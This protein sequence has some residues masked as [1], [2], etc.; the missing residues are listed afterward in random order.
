[1]PFMVWTDNNLLNYV[2]TTLNLDATG[3]TCVGALASFEFTLEYQKGTDNGA[4]DALSQVPICLG[5]ETVLSLLEST[6]MGATDRGEA[7]ATK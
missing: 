5:Y 7:E 6:I 2:L 1:M 3:H 4:A